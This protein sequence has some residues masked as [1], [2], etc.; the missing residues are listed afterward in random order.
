M[1]YFQTNKT[2]LNVHG[3]LVFKH[4]FLHNLTWFYR[5]QHLWGWRN[6][7]FAEIFYMTKID[8]QWPEIF[9]NHFF[10]IS[11]PRIGN[12]KYIFWQ[13]SLRSSTKR[14]INCPVFSGRK[15]VRNI[16]LEV[17]SPKVCPY[18]QAEKSLN[19]P[20]LSKSEGLKIRKH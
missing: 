19:C 3:I 13:I 2:K 15:I 11:S 5:P 16:I 17:L 18:K 20:L 8:T 1:T 6:W 14:P 10:T 4:K 12:L 9:L 7:Q